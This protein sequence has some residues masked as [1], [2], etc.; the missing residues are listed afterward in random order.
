[1]FGTENKAL[2]IFLVP[3]QIDQRKGAADRRKTC[4]GQRKGILYEPR[5]ICEGEY[6]MFFCRLSCYLGKTLG[7]V[8]N[9]IYSISLLT[10]I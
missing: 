1:M 3:P 9:T 10:V 6:R 7:C 2:T 4:F 5:P 8:D